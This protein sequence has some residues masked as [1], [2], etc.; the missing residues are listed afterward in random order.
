MRF[1]DEVVAIYIH[2]PD[3]MSPGVISAIE[4]QGH[5]PSKFS[6]TGVWAGPE[7]LQF[8]REGKISAIVAPPAMTVA[9]LSVQYLYDLKSGK[10]IP[11]IGDTVIEE[12]AVWSPAKVVLNPYC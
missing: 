8:I 4:K 2:T 1:G 6:I 11:Q 5:D 12:G 9:E 3:I 10:K 7:G